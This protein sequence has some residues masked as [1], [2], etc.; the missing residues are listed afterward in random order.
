MI[1]FTHI[2]AVI[3][4]AIYCLFKHHFFDATQASYAVQLEQ[5]VQI[6]LDASVSACILHH[7][8]THEGNIDFDRVTLQLSH[9]MQEE[10][11]S[12]VAYHEIAH[13]LSIGKI[14]RIN[15][16]TYLRPWGICSTSYHIFDAH[17]TSSIDRTLYAQNEKLNECLACFLYEQIEKKTP[18][19]N[20]LSIRG[21]YGLANQHHVL[22]Y[23]L[24][25]RVPQI[26]PTITER[27]TTNN[28]K[29]E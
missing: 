23:Y 14:L 19:P 10:R 25:H 2:H 12:Y 11:E 28:E 26:L 1:T 5:R 9:N 29:E 3:D 13:L 24:S 7:P 6:R 20:I 8:E 27:P 15:D 22:K 18:P 16:E 17:I 4:Q 21:A